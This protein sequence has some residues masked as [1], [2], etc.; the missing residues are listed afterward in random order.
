MASTVTELMMRRMM[1]ARS[2]SIDWE[3]VAR[4]LLDN[5]L[6]F[7][8]PEVAEVR[9]QSNQQLF[10]R[11]KMSGHATIKSGCTTIGYQSFAY[12]KLLQGVTIPDTVTSIGQSA[13]TQC[14]ALTEVEI[15]SSVTSIA[16][17]A[18]MSCTS[19]V[20]VICKRTTPPTLATSSFQGCTALTSIYVPDANVNAY[21]SA[22]GWSDYASIIKPISQ[23][24]T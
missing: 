2:A 10:T 16:A 7:T 20:D 11:E 23:R 15:P 1:G 5:S 17:Q 6:E 21:K 24:P 12:C 19:L 22:S 8:L 14:Y 4:G 18:F 13:F 9:T 3:S